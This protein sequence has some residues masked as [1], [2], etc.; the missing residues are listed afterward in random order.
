MDLSTQYLG[1]NL[2]N[3]I[4]PSA[5]PMT[6]ELDS[7]RRLEDAGA[8]A[9]VLPSLFEEQLRH[10]VFELDYHL[11]HG[12]ESF[13]E[14]LSYFPTGDEFRLG[15]DEFS[16]IGPGLFY[17]CSHVSAERMHAGWIAVILTEIGHHGF[18]HFRR[19]HG[20]GI[21]GGWGNVLRRLAVANVCHVG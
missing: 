7:I 2:D 17:F 12:T 10:E 8:A 9:V 14:A 21:G 13:S 19:D 15:P 20:R 16:D 1:F 5:G 4:V 11:Q 6:A 3:P 18:Q